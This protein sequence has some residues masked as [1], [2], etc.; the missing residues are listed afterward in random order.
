MMGDLAVDY[1]LAGFRAADQQIVFFFFDAGRLVFHG[2]AVLDDFV[3]KNFHRSSAEVTGVFIHRFQTKI[4]KP[5]SATKNRRP[6]KDRT[7]VGG[8]WEATIGIIRPAG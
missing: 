1:S 3:A 4:R 5:L 7:T 2:Q 8:L 6:G